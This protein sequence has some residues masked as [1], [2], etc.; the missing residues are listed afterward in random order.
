MIKSVSQPENKN[1][2]PEPNIKKEK[3]QPF[4]SYLDYY[5]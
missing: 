1:K 5:I 2:E 3:N 4:E